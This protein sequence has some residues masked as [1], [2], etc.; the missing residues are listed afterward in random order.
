MVDVVAKLQTTCYRWLWIFSGIIC[1]F[2]HCNN[3]SWPDQLCLVCGIVMMFELKCSTRINNFESFSQYWSVVVCRT[4]I[5]S[6]V[7]WFYW[8]LDW[9][10]RRTRLMNLFQMLEKLVPNRESSAGGASIGGRYN[11]DDVQQLRYLSSKILQ[12]VTSQGTI[13]PIDLMRFSR[14][15]H[16]RTRV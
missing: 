5:H 4:A 9:Y 7:D 12:Y 6:F 3:V 8:L 2:L 15:Q 16:N 11:T 10:T 13:Q 1:F 14:W